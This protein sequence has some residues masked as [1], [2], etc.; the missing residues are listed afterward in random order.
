MPNGL[1]RGFQV[2]QKLNPLR[3]QTYPESRVF[4]QN[5]QKVNDC[6][7]QHCRFQGPKLRSLRP[8][9]V[10]PPD[11]KLLQFRVHR[12]SLPSVVFWPNRVSRPSPTI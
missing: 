1:P 11:Q 8:N 4:P 2:V 6:L 5:P 10:P 3:D 9:P 7:L 12:L